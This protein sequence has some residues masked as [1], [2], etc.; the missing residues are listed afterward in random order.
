MSDKEPTNY[1]KLRKSLD[2]IDDAD[3]LKNSPEQ[4]KENRMARLLAEFDSDNQRRA[5]QTGV[6]SQG[7]Y[8]PTATTHP[9]SNITGRGFGGEQTPTGCQVVFG[10]FALAMI[11]LSL[12]AILGGERSSSSPSQPSQSS[13]ES[14]YSSSTELQRESDRQKAYGAFRD[15]GFNQTDS[16]KLGRAVEHMHNQDKEIR[17]QRA[18]RGL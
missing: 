10:L 11:P 8:T 13:Y 9:T 2:A 18:R 15:Q 7:L 5:A 14:S 17:R 12:L 3:E 6:P 4:E 16:E 1:E